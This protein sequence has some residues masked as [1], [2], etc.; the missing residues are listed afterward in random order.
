MPTDLLLADVLL[1][2]EPGAAG[3]GDAEPSAIAVDHGRI[4]EIG[5][6]DRLRAVYAGARTIACGRRRAIPGLIDSHLHAVR[7][8]RTWHAEVR[9]DGLGSL[10]EALDLLARRCATAT[11]GSWLRVTGGWHPAQFAE[12][13]LPTRAELDDAAP[14]HPVYAQLLFEGAVLNT[15]AMRACPE[16]AGPEFVAGLP[17]LRLLD[18]SVGEPDEETATAST[19]AFLRMVSAVGVTGVSD[20]NGF[21]V[22]GAVYRPVLELWRARRL[23]VRLRLHLGPGGPGREVATYRRHAEHCFAGFGDGMLRTSGFGEIPSFGCT[24]REGLESGRRPSSEGRRTLAEVSRIALEH[25]WP[26]HVHAILRTT[27]DAVLD[28]W[29]EIAAGASL[30]PYRFAICHAETIGPASI[31]RAAR[32]G[33]GVAVQNRLM[34][35]GSDSARAWGVTIAREA[36]PLRDL[37]DAGIPLGGGTDGTVAN[38]ADPW[39]ALWWMITGRSLDGSPARGER[40]R[41][42][43]SEALA[44]FTA[45]SAWFTAEEHDRGVLAPGRAADLAVLSED[46]FTIAEDAIP[47]IRSLLTVV[48]GRV[49]HRDPGPGDLVTT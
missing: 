34:L 27:I 48:D 1:P 25:G 9:W 28:V 41:L 5:P 46:L 49:V 35:R 30:A 17:A 13:R 15:R 10:T 19:E 40:H 29:E 11:P 43:R 47:R 2:P 32:L 7:A 24:D 3:S 22:M 18:R 4:V 31:E 16:L 37:I 6:T 12:A 38:S 8:G 33:I 45:G 21:G 39:R 20:M 42:T 26:M 44:V 36:P 14:D 23:P